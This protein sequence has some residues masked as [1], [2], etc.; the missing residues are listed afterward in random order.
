MH[1]AS[2]SINGSCRRSISTAVGGGCVSSDVLDGCGY[3]QR[4]G[5]PITNQETPASASASKVS[6]LFA[7]T[8]QTRYF[9][10]KKGG[11]IDKSKFTH[12]T[13]V[14]FPDVSDDDAGFDGK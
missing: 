11:E 14:V 8:Q 7:N 9:S 5:R 1:L 13:K 4:Y 2:R 6:G 10:G 12:E 3:S